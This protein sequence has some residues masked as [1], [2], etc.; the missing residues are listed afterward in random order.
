MSTNRGETLL[1]RL[2]A[3]ILAA[4]AALLALLMFAA[5]LRISPWALGN[6]PYYGAATLAAAIYFGVPGRN[7]RHGRALVEGAEYYAVLTL[8]MLIGA[9]ASYPA[10]ALTHGY[11][12]EALYRIDRAIGFDWV[13][14]YRFVAAHPLL[15]DLGVAAYRSIYVTP[16]VL[17]AWFASTGERNEAYRLIVTFQIAAIVTLAVFVFLPAV[18]PFSYLWHGPV[19]YIPES[20]TWQAGLIPA[21]RMKEIG[22]VD[23]AH[24]RG[25]VSAPSFH[26]A[27]AVIFINAAWRAGPLRW[28]LIALNIAMLFA[29]PVEGTHYLIDLIMGAVAAAIAILATDA[30]T[31]LELRPSRMAG[32]RALVSLTGA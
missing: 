29:T 2:V 4:S 14:W 6:L 27:A 17:L 12:D 32:D 23:L 18:G 28:P 21:L 26:A 9:I 1:P 10:A 19:P 7:W 3:G 24:L 30:I 15:Q 11:H 22:I 5:D 13:G 25:L 31:R 8:T 20:E 16:A